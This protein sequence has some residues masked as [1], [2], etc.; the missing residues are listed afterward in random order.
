MDISIRT[1]TEDDIEFAVSQTT[2][3]GW[4]TTAELFQAALALD[5]TGSFIGEARNKRVAMM[6]TTRYAQT[7]WIGNLIVPPEHQR[8]GIGERMMRHAMQ[9]LLDC[10]VRTIRL[11]ADPPGINIYRRL[12]FVDE[13]ESFRFLRGPGPAARGGGAERLSPGDLSEV[14]AFDLDRFGDRRGRLLEFL[15]ARAKTAHWVRDREQVRG[16]AFVVASRE[17]LQIGPCVARDAGTAEQL[18]TS[19]LSEAGDEAVFLGVPSVS[20]DAV[21]LFESHGFQRTPSSYRMVYGPK[22]ASGH[23]ECIFAIANGAMG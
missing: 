19:A 17:G 14:A 11:E 6:T 1:F 5:P 9:Y 21:S 10:G 16:Y 4:E 8:Q 22:V 12:G 3:E 23:P 7:G 15:L 2:R 20:E 13:F 18:L